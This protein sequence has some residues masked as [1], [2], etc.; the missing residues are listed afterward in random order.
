MPGTR[1]K[2]RTPVDERTIGKRLRELR[3]QRG[4][5]QNEVAG[6]LGINQS[7]V[8]D[9]EKGVVRMH[10]ALVAGFARILKV[11]TDQILGLEKPASNG[12][13]KDR[14]FVRRL[15]RIDKLT[16]RDRQLLLGTI[17]AFLA[18]LPTEQR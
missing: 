1:K 10:A 6:E 8:S 15:E 4:M 16:K 9:Y 5:T 12:H 2:Y 13:I 11:T 3:L 7:A 14:R 17:D 18:K